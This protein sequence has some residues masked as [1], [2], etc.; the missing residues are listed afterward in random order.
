MDLYNWCVKY[1]EEARDNAAVDEDVSDAVI[2]RE[3][4]KLETLIFQVA[5]SFVDNEFSEAE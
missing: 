5:S 3:A 2:E 1:L 4:K